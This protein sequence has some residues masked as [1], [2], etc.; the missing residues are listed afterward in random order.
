[1]K[2]AGAGASQ[3]IKDCDS[4]LKRTK[5]VACLAPNRRVLI[6]MHNLPK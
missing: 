2:V 6:E 3:P 5:L 4:K 1:M